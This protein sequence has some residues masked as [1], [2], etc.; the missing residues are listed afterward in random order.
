[1][2]RDK[3]KLSVSNLNVR[4]LES[5]GRVIKAIN[6]VSLEVRKGESIGIAG[7]SASGK[8]T[9]GS[10]IMRNLESNARITSG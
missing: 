4:Y 1:M 8:S 6:S 9:L 7:E 2:K 10:A 3:S 5:S